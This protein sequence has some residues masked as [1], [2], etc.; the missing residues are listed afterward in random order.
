MDELEEVFG[1]K[2][3]FI[4][5]N[6]DESVKRRKAHKES[7]PLWKQLE[8]EDKEEEMKHKNSAQNN[9]EGAGTSK[10]S[11]ENLNSVNS[12][13]DLIKKQK[14]DTSLFTSQG[15]LDKTNKIENFETLGWSDP[16]TCN[17][18]KVIKNIKNI[19]FENFVYPEELMNPD[20]PP[21]CIF[22][23]S[24]AILNKMIE[25]AAKH[26]N[27]HLLL[28]RF[29]DQKAKPYVYKNWREQKEMFK[30]EN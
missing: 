18:T 10:Q 27:K 11:V 6:L 12:D 30:K 4:G 7:D 25:A 9:A 13:I 17:A 22:V 23:P 14:A 24:T 8:E 19:T 26:T 15:N 3:A 5:S 1:S 28:A 20:K 21:A 2:V 16:V 29:S